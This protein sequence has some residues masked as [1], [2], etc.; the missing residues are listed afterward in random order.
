MALT[1]VAASYETGA[2]VTLVFDRAVD[3][4]GLDAGQVM[5]ND[6]AEPPGVQYVGTGLVA[7]PDPQSV[8][9]GLSPSGGEPTVPGVTLTA[10]PLTGIVAVDDGG[11]WGGVF[12]MTL[13]FP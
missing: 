11:T 5:V 12:G 8:Q 10:S 2:S 9:I 6:L 13:P 3:A 4:A 7:Q 1:L